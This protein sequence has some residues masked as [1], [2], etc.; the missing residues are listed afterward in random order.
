MAASTA[1][2]LAS[3]SE[4]ASASRSAL[5]AAAAELVG[6]AL[7]CAHAVG[8][9]VRSRHEGQSECQHRSAETPRSFIPR[10]LRI[11]GGQ[12]L[13]VGVGLSYQSESLSLSVRVSAALSVALPVE[14]WATG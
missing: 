9:G 13:S 4:S 3:S 6:G 1:G 2:A 7:T 12:N 10:F 5:L 8:G 11:T 14:R